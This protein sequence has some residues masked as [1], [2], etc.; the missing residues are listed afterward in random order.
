MI[1]DIKTSNISFLKV[2]KYLRDSGIKNNKFMLV[3]YDK[4]L[5][6]VDPYSDEVENNVELQLRI[7]RE[8]CKNSWYYL[9]EIVRIPAD[10]RDSPYEANIANITM[11]YLKER[12]KNVVEILP[13]Q[14]GKTMSNVVWD[15]WPTLFITRNAN[16]VYLN[17]GK[18]DAV[19]NL[20]IFKDIKERLPMW[21]RQ[22][23]VEDAKKDI[24]N[25]ENKLIALR[26]NTLRVVS[27]GTDEDHADKQGR[28]LTVSNIYWDEFSFTKYCDITYQA[29]IPA[30]KKAA[31]NAKKNGTPY[32]FIITTTPAN[33]DTGPGAFCYSVIG[34]SATWKLDL[35]DFTNEQL[36]EYISANSE[37][38]FIFVQYT[39]KELGRDD[40]WLKEMIR[41]CQGDI[42]KVKREIL[43]E[44]PKSMDSSVFNEEQLD[45]IFQFVKQPLSRIYIDG[46]YPIEFYEIPDINKN[47]ILSCDVAG[48]LSRDNS[49]IN[50]IDPED[51][52][53]VG[54]FISNRID[55]DSFKKVIIELM[56]FYMRN[57]LLVI[58]KNSYGLNIIQS[59]MKD[60]MIEPRM[61]RE[62][63][64]TLGEKKQ[65]NGFTVKKKTKTISYGVDTNAQTRKQ[66][67]DLLPEI[68][69]TEYDK[70]VSPN[71]Y[72]DISNLEKKK[73]GKIE[74]SAS[75]HDDSLMAYLIFRYAVFYGKCFRDRFGISSIPSRMNVKVQ[76]SAADM[77]KISSLIQNANN[78][79]SMQTLS[80]NSTFEY[81]ADQQRKLNGDSDSQLSA[82]LRVTRLN[83]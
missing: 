38:N 7:Y 48:G 35:F 30:W 21:L 74:H 18:T 49:V 40:E 44:W 34:K 29:C 1:Y 28:G 33:L 50:I 42:A 57:A 19:K 2:S 25:Q 41:D 65:S 23:F 77:T 5:S 3:L 31:E 17:K 46:K 82:F 56:T 75:G 32:G 24:D 8:I 37:N 9:R 80:G 59:L 14:H 64:E 43:L 76:S 13:R 71:I 51:F 12:N 69:D 27:P 36:D 68:V 73:T 52:R 6:G 10:G 58:E 66:M 11:A 62:D 61:Y 83:K 55:T 53:I 15:T 79:A 54:D 47:Y 60:P 20:K 78:T 45:K 81:I 63:K 26:N 4:T 70:F 67:F 22:K 16:Y 72:K 39:Y